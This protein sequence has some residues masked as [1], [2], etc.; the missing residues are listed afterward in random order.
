LLA[1]NLIETELFLPV[2]IISNFLKSWA[3]SCSVLTGLTSLNG[4]LQS[5]RDKGNQ[6]EWQTFINLHSKDLHETL[7]L[8]SGTDLIDGRLTDNKRSTSTNDRVQKTD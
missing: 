4:L 5:H 1:S 2:S 3:D 7:S 6:R 8:P